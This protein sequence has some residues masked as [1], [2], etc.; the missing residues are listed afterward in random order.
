L[1]SVAA[2]LEEVRKIVLEQKQ[3]EFEKSKDFIKDQL[4]QEIS[5]KMWGTAAEVEASFGS[6]KVIQKGVEFLSNL[7]EYHALLKVADQPKSK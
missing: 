4:R 7:D 3:M 2:P 6:D 1:A 5:A